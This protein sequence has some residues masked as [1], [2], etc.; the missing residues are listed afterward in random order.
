MDRVLKNVLRGCFYVATK[1]P[2]PPTTDILIA[3]DR[4]LLAP[5]FHALIAHL[6]K[7]WNHFGDD[8]FGCRYRRGVDDDGD[9]FACLMNFY[10]RKFYLGLTVTTLF[11]DRNPDLV[12]QLRRLS[13]D[14]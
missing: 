11:K 2:L 13:E 10:R 8:V 5:P 7:A 6:P 4:E 1:E 14:A 3:R 12:G 9:F